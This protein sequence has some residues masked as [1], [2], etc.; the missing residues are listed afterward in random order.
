MEVG[1]GVDSGVTVRLGIDVAL[2]LDVGCTT[3]GGLVDAKYAIIP[4]IVP[5]ENKITRTK[6]S[7][8]DANLLSNII[9]LNNYIFIL[10]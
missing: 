3:T 10:A 6:V 7:L 5:I 4:S 2:E 8:A 1:V 9:I